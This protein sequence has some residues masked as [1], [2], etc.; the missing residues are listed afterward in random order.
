MS[1]PVLFKDLPDLALIQ[2]R[3]LIDY[4][5]VPYSATT[6]WRF[7]K[8]G[9]FPAPIKVSDGVTAWRVGDIRK[10]LLAISNRPQ[11][12]SPKVAERKKRMG[13]PRKEAVKRSLSLEDARQQ[14]QAMTQDRSTLL[15]INPYRDHVIE[16]VAQ[17][18]LKME[19]FG[20]DTLNSFAIYIRG[21]K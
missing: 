1:K 14:I 21:L 16:E 5:V 3:G 4:K 6:I 10:Y 19:G 13:R 17:A 18:I 7:V 12:D 15:A 8:K 2:I 9:Q 11:D 20:Q